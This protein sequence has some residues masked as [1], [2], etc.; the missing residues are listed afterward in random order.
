MF[1]EK[2]CNIPFLYHIVALWLEMD[3]E[4]FSTIVIPWNSLFEHIIKVFWCG[5]QDK[6]IIQFRSKLHRYM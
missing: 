1:S 6:K 2:N 5:R 4:R 3:K